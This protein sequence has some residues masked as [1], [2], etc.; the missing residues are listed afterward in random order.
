MDAHPD[1]A[2]LAA[3]LARAG[4]ASHLIRIDPAALP[5]GLDPAAA[6][7]ALATALAATA[8]TAAAPVFRL[9]PLTYALDPGGEGAEALAARLP[10]PQALQVTPIAAPPGAAD[11]AAACLARGTARAALIAG[12]QAM[13]LLEAGLALALAERMAERMAGQPAPGDAGATPAPPD[14][15]AARILA[16]LGNQRM[17]LNGLRAQLRE[18]DRSLA[19][20]PR[21]AAPRPLLDRLDR[22]TALIEHGEMPARAGG[23]P[24]G[25]R[26]G[27]DLSPDG[28][29]R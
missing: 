25:G 8:A 6:E 1:C 22:L 4:L 23:R 27:P 14:G 13:L 20:G 10:W 16:E 7:A 11:P 21:L 24:G 3:R 9:A 17:M 5:A 29:A 19:L 15:A 2:T 18:I 28:A 26:P 12:P